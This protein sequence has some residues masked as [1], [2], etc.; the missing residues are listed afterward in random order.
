MLK[1]LFSFINRIGVR[2]RRD[3]NIVLETVYLTRSG[4]PP[5]VR[6]LLFKFSYDYIEWNIMGIMMLS[7]FSKQAKDH[8]CR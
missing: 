7:I 4:T 1:G 2:A 6:E 8:H 3:T 5:S